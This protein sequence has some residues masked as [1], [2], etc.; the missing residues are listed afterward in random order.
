[1]S[2]YESIII[3]EVQEGLLINQNQN[4]FIIKTQNIDDLLKYKE[5]RIKIMREKDG[6][7]HYK[8][9]VAKV[10]ED[11]VY[12]HHIALLKKEQRRK[13]KRIAYEQN[14]LVNRVYINDQ[15]SNLDQNIPFKSKNFSGSGVSL[16]SHL[17]LPEEFSFFIDC[18]FIKKYFLMQVKIIRTEKINGEYV[19]GCV[20]PFATEEESDLIRQHL[21]KVQLEEI[22]KHKG[23]TK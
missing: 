7:I 14:F 18:S 8:G 9:K 11:E 6:L 16:V 12:V 3:N 23:R 19:Y 5:I 1:M 15:V 17:K 2:I 22:K 10:I 20:F 4:G 21:Y 13:E